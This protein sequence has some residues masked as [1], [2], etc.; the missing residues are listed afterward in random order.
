MQK[1]AFKMD[2][3]KMV[4]PELMKTILGAPG[5]RSVGITHERTRILGNF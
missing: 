2:F 4:I 5:A 1:E 3:V